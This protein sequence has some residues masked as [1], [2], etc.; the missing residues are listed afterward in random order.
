M[1]VKKFTISMPEE[2]YELYK[3]K[4][5]AGGMSLSQFLYRAGSVTTVEQAVTFPLEQNA[6][7]ISKLDGNR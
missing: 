3:A 2:A 5:G 1:A 4:A 7:T 6:G